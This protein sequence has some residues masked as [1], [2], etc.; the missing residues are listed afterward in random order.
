VVDG[1]CGTGLAPGTRAV[2]RRARANAARR[3]G[4]GLTLLAALGACG[5]E[6][7]GDAPALHAAGEPTQVVEGMTLRESDAGRLR[8]V[9]EADSAL[10]FGQGAPTRLYGMHVDFYNTAGDSIRSTLTAREGEIGDKQ[11]DLIA[12]GRVVVRTALGHTLETEELRWDRAGGKVVSNRFVRLTKGGSVLT[13]IG[14]ESDPELR[15]YRIL[16]EIE[17]GVREGE[18]ILDGF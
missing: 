16:S 4:I 11:E 13:G 12:R 7:H 5:E 6:P 9:L 14:I 1:M 3:L 10:A 18:P 17:A 2:G 8:W 15:S